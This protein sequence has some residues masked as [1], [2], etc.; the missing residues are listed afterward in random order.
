MPADIFYG[1]PTTSRIY[2][3]FGYLVINYAP[4]SSRGQFGHR[5]AQDQM[6]GRTRRPWRRKMDVECGGCGGPDLRVPSE[7]RKPTIDKSIASN[8]SK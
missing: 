7:S 3:V 1:D 5:T 2:K 6:R 8:D 4:S